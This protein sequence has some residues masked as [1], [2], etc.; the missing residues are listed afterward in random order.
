[1]QVHIQFNFKV[2]V[3]YDTEENN[4]KFQILYIIHIFTSQNFLVTTKHM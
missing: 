4:E 3:M 1:M 2:W